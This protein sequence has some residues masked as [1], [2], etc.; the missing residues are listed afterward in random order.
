[1]DA[2]DFE[3]SAEDHDDYR[4]IRT[5]LPRL[6][7]TQSLSVV[8]DRYLALWEVD[9]PILIVNDATRLGELDDEVSAVLLAILKRNLLDPKFRG[10][11][12]YTGGNA[13]LD[14]QLRELH[15]EAGRDP[16]SIVVT[17]EEALAYI[18]RCLSSSD[19]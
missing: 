4:L 8:I 9:L 5:V 19:R 15:V 3:F 14:A 13:R 17:E 12:W 7:T 6:V 10:S 18:D 2:T 1:M 11:S 16:D